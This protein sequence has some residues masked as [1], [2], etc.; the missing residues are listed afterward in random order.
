MK[1]LKRITALFLLSAVLAVLLAMPA[2]AST[3]VSRQDGLE[4]TVEMDKEAYDAG[5][6]ITATITVKNTSA[7]AVAIANLEQLIPEGYELSQSS[8]AAAQNIEL[9]PNQTFEMKVTFEGSSEPQA[10]FS[11]QGFFD[12]VIYGQTKGVPNLLIAVLVVIA[13]VIFMLLT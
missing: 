12:K 11:A 1:I 10:E 8:K 3:T 6:P 9:R 4:V 13:F 5:E 2:A 7:E